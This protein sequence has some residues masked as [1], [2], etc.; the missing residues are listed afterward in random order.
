MT[1]ADR[2]QQLID[3]RFKAWQETFAVVRAEL[4]VTG[5]RPLMGELLTDPDVNVGLAR[6]A[7]GIAMARLVTAND[8]AAGYIAALLVANGIKP[9]PQ[10]DMIGEG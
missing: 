6:I 9:I 2:N 3:A 4:E 7:Q 5:S 8:R 1:T 10:E